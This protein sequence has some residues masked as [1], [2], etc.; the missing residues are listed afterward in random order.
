MLR[1]MTTRK[2][3]FYSP[4]RDEKFI[5]QGNRIIEDCPEWCKQDLMFQAAEKAGIL[6][7]LVLNTPTKVEQKIQEEAPKNAHEEKEVAT[8]KAAAKKTSAKKGK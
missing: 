2:L 5:T 1:I 6:T 8:K 7:E 3:A 4:K